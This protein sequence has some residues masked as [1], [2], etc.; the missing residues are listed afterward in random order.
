MIRNAIALTLTAVLGFHASLSAASIRVITDRT[1][2]HLKPLMSDFEK[3]SGIKTEVVYVGKAMMARL[4]AQP[5]EADV[6]ITK[7]AEN[8]E[9]ARKA[10][11][12]QSFSSKVL[13]AL[14]ARFVDKDKQYVVTSYRSRGFFLSRE[15]VKAGQISSYLD[16]VKPEWKGKIAIRSGY[17][18][19]N[20]SLFSQMVE[21]WGAEKTKT[22]LK[23]LKANLARVP[24]GN[25][26]AQIQAIHDGKADISIGNSYYMAI[27]LGRE[28]QVPWAKATKV[29]FPDQ[30][31]KGAFIMRAG[32]GLTKS[33]RNVAG[34]TKL[35]E[36]LVG[37][38]AQKYLT[39]A[40]NVYSVRD[41]FT[42]S[43]INKTL[44]AEQPE[45]KE[46][47]F[48][49]NWGSLRS[50]DQHRET[51]IKILNELNFDQK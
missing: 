49:A 19:Y 22:F 33:T 27:M 25:D 15:R 17:H 46:G 14:P 18:P 30:K 9:W 23:G 16:L 5:T 7:T 29:M 24:Q 48:K 37:E 34:A 11:L 28:D 38:Y 12:L 45:V 47:K 32:A 39:E 1:E 2:S 31:G 8:M 21:A 26:R 35:L 50:V 4:K 43:K 41:G 40:L 36:Y 51:V 3:T 10:K 13:T 20:V 6:V 44:G 42:I